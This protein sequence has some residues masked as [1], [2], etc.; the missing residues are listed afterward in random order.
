MPMACVPVQRLYL[1]E[2]QRY[3]LGATTYVSAGAF[4]AAAAFAPV[5]ADRDVAFRIVIVLGIAVFAIFLVRVFA[6]TFGRPA[7]FTLISFGQLWA[8]PALIGYELQSL[9]RGSGLPLQSVVANSEP[10]ALGACVLAASLVYLLNQTT[11]PDRLIALTEAPEQYR[12]LF[13]SP[14]RLALRLEALAFGVYFA[15]GTLLRLTMNDLSADTFGTETVWCVLAAALAARSTQAWVLA[16]PVAATLV[17]FIIKSLVPARFSTLTVY[18]A[19][20]LVLVLVI[21]HAQEASRDAAA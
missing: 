16:G 12:L 3:D 2:G 7:D 17:R 14:F 15:A 6:L 4:V 5:P 19:L 20:A 10:V 9:T 21:T 8:T 18:A 11:L 1:K 13:G